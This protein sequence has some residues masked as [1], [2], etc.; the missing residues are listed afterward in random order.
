LLLHL[1]NAY[2]CENLG[3]GN[4]PIAPHPLVAGMLINYSSKAFEIPL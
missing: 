3:G 1:T 2:V 4:C